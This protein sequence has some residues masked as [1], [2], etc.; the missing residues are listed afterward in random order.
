MNWLWKIKT[1]ILFFYLIEQQVLK[2][3]PVIKQQRTI[4][5]SNEKYHKKIK[6][7]PKSVLFKWLF[8]VAPLRHRPPSLTLHFLCR[9][10]S[11]AGLSSDAVLVFSRAVAGKHHVWEHKRHL[12]FP[13]VA[14]VSSE[15]SPQW[16]EV[17]PVETLTFWL[18]G[19]RNEGTD[20]KQLAAQWRHDRLSHSVEESACIWLMHI[21]SV[22]LLCT[23]TPF[24]PS[25]TN[26]QVW[27][28][29]LCDDVWRFF[30]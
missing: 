15:T 19:C 4:L 17:R 27:I 18:R 5:Y 22:I 14:H 3:I 23:H 20:T 25:N 11:S 24:L 26:N 2:I 6:I 30:F 10:L 21:L 16:K 28:D 7:F 13:R 12:T 29:A 1:N 9:H 8:G